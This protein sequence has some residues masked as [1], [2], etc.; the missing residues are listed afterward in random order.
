MS[1]AKAFE[2]YL[3]RLTDAEEDI[4]GDP[5]IEMSLQVSAFRTTLS[6]MKTPAVK[7]PLLP[8][9][10]VAAIALSSLGLAPGEKAPDFSAPNQD[11]KAIK[12]SSFKGKPVLLYFY[13]KDDTPGCTKEACT[14]RDEF[15]KFKKQG[16]V[17]LGVSRQDAKSHSAFKNKYHLPFDLLVDQNGDIAKAYGVHMMPVVGLHQRESVLLDKNQNV[18]RFYP[19]VNPAEHANEVLKD[20]I[21]YEKSHS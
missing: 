5:I 21:D 2:K 11:G 7:R 18:I 4:E 8:F 13:P 3:D 20:L 6:S 17:V 10:T 14:L 19:D 15:A 9:L 16:A 12:L 1:V